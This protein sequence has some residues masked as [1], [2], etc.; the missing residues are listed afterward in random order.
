[1]PVLASKVPEVVSL[2]QGISS[3]ELPEYMDKSI[4]ALRTQFEYQK[5]WELIYYV[6]PKKLALK[7]LEFSKKLLSEAKEL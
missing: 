4:E 5:R 3:F 6:F 2:G 7:F 1:M